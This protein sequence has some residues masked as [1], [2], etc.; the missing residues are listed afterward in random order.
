M[1][2]IGLMGCGAVA[3]FGHLPAIATTSGLEISALYDPDLARV[4]ELGAS[5]PNAWRFTDPEEFFKATIDA[6]VIASPAPAHYDNLKLCAQ[7]GKHVLCEKPLGHTEQEALAMIDLMHQRGLMLF[8]GFCYRF[9]PV[10]LKIKE[11]IESGEIGSVMAMRLIYLWALDGKYITGPDGA[12]I[13]NPRREARMLEGGPMVDCGVHLIDLARWWLNSEVVAHTG[14]GAWLEEY[15]APDH[16]WLHLNLA[17]GAVVHVE[18]SFSYTATASDHLSQFTYEIIG[19]EGLIRYD[20][21]GW[22]LEVRNGSGTHHHPG[23]SEKNFYGMYT[24]FE[25]ALRTGVPG[26]L[27]SGE[28]GVIA[29]RV[30][31]EATEQAIVSRTELMFK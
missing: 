29:T 19:T 22:R 2:K 27:P 9:S 28:D 12:R 3:S 25:E 10:S 14:F 16:V 30:A 11:L 13:A 31:N 6:V 4:N 26:H 8:T 23:A 21:D 1:F 24:A 5:Y 15:R 17:S 7:H 20:R 18:T